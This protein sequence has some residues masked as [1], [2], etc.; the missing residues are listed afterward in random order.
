MMKALMAL[1]V[2]MSFVSNVAAVE[3][4][5]SPPSASCADVCKAVS[6]GKDR[7]GHSFYVCRG[8][9]ANKDLRP[10][11]NVSTS[12]DSAGKCL[13]EYGGR[14]GESTIYDCLCH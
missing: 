5:K 13:F 2:S 8:L 11:F 4:V 10:G 12:K 14:R 7:L 9:A 6:S 1:L 3:W